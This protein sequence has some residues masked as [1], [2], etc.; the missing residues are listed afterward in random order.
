[1]PTQLS[2]VC[3]IVKAERKQKRGTEHVFIQHVFMQHVLMQHVLMLHVLNIISEGSTM[4]GGG[5]PL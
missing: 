2:R 5:F 1:V 3:S 4:E